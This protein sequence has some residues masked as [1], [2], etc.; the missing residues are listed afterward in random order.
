MFEGLLIVGVMFFLVYKALSLTEEPKDKKPDKKPPIWQMSQEEWQGGHRGTKQYRT[1]ALD[2]DRVREV[3]EIYRKPESKPEDLPVVFEAPVK[4]VPRPPKFGII[5][6]K[7]PLKP[8]VI[9]QEESSIAVYRPNRLIASVIEET[10][11]EYQLPSGAV[12]MPVQETGAIVAIILYLIKAEPKIGITKLEYYIILLDKMCFQ[13][14]G[15]RLF[16]Y[17]LTYGPYG[18][19]IQNFRAFLDFLE[20]KGVI[21]K[22]RDYYARRKYRID[23]KTHHEVSEAIF[24]DPIRGWIRQILF[25]W[26]GAGAD[27][28]KRGILG[29]FNAL[30]IEAFTLN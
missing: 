26:K 6:D 20:D 22:R 9:N 24:P 28:T 16:N 13:E 12:D 23:F 27:H 19:F 18:Y 2:S 11:K 4:P 21:S 29:Q 3:I 17:R 30:E 7:P 8:E 5:V 14:T 1:K 10:G 25:T 15:Q